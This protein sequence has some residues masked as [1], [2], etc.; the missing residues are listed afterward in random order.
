MHGTTLEPIEPGPESDNPLLIAPA[1]SVHT[2]LGGWARFIQDA[3]AG[4]EGRGALLSSASY[5]QLFEAP[6]GGEYAHGWVRMSRPALGGVAYMHAGS[7][8]LNSALAWLAPK[9]R[10]AVI[11]VTNAGSGH[12]ME[13]CD[14][15]LGVLMKPRV[16]AY[17]AAQH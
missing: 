12:S 3:L 7:N 4:L 2:S 1:G 17:R 11:V 14:Q 13:A 6:F 8:T 9:L 10:V 16:Q 5:A 15:V